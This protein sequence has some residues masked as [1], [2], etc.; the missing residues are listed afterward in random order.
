MDLTIDFLERNFAR[1]A[2]FERMYGGRVYQ[3]ND[4]VYITYDGCEFEL[5]ALYYDNDCG[6]DALTGFVSIKT[7]EQLK[8]FIEIIGI[9]KTYLI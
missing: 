8:S 2:R 9:D 7:V 4:D 5:N 1:N 6:C 3:L